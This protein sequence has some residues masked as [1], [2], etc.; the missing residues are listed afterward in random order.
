MWKQQPKAGLY[1]H[2]KHPAMG[3]PASVLALLYCSMT[4]TPIYFFIMVFEKGLHYVAL[5]GLEF[6]IYTRRASNFKVT[7]VL[8]EHALGL[9]AHSTRTSYSMHRWT[10]GYSL[11][12]DCLPATGKPWVPSPIK[13]SGCSYLL[14]FRMVAGLFGCLC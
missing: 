12:A 7:L 14:L 1:V 8:H 2:G 3:T 13:L 5:N 6:D 4:H 11:A 10:V 9:W